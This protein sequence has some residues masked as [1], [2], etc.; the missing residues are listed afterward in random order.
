MCIVENETVSPHIFSRSS[1]RASERS[2]D[3]VLAALDANLLVKNDECCH[4]RRDYIMLCKESA[5]GLGFRFR[6]RALARECTQR[7]ARLALFRTIR[8]R[9]VV[10]AP[11]RFDKVGVREGGRAGEGLSF[12]WLDVL[13]ARSSWRLL[14]RL[15]FQAT[16]GGAAR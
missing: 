14:S 5:R 3:N 16:G 15:G 6:M 2:A 13:F 12:S 7:H 8:D 1:E 10:G 4:D 11:T 9:A